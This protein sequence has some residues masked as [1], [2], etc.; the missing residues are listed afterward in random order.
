MYASA[1]ACEE[2]GSARDHR[3]GG[4]RRLR[5]LPVIVALGFILPSIPLKAETLQEA[6]V[7]AYQ[8]HPQLN[9]E[10]ARQR[11]TDEG[12][13]QALAAYRPQINASLSAGLLGVRNLLPDGEVQAANL[14]SWSAGIT[15]SQTLFNGFR[16]GNSVRQAES[17]VFAGR[18]TLRNVEQ[19]VFLDVVTVYANVFAGNSLVEAQRINVQFMRD[20]LAATRKRQELGDVTPTDVAQAEARFN[21]AL[22][23][24]N[25]AEV[26]FAINQATYS[27]V[28]G[29][30][31]GRLVAAEPIDQL[32]PPVRDQAVAISRREHPAIVA[33][34]YDIDVAQHA[35]RV[36]E[37]SLYPTV[38]LQAQASRNVNTDT[39]LGT[40]RSDV[41]S[42][43]TNATV[44]IYDG[45]LAASQIRQGKEQLAQVRAQLDRARGQIQSAVIAGWVT[46]EGAKIA[47]Q[48]AQSEARAADLALAGVQRETR[49]GQRTT[50]DVLNAQQDLV[51]ARARLIQAQRDRVIASYTLLAAIGRLDHAR[52][53]LNTPDYSP[54]THYHQVRDAWRGLRTPAGQ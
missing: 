21:R 46:H 15:A 38:T 36:A 23:D 34:N 8:G 6:L 24:L 1:N 26:T 22:A 40:P 7:L 44:P 43:T 42:V 25:S 11:S 47:V 30:A 51:A 50:L 49:A 35:I 13:P 19:S 31:P 37:G 2:V 12:V 5:L 53:A 54:Q 20:T 3:A 45:G 33:A 48:A 17:Q 27:Q 29:N 41:A 16:T 28:V 39:T 52:L 9:A 32:L 14:R 10:R 18:E 4:A